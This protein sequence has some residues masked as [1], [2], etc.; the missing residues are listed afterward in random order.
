MKVIK[1]ACDNPKCKSVG[2]PEHV[3]D[4]GSYSPPYGWV[5][6]RVSWFGCGPSVTVE[7]CKLA[8]LQKAVND[9]EDDD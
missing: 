6:A 2:T 5:T 9:A 3:E 7:V 4:D 1:V 8:C